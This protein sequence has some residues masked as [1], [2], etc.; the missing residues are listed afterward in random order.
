MNVITPKG[1]NQDFNDVSWKYVILIS[2]C[3]LQGLPPL[4]VQ[5]IHRSIT[6]GYIMKKWSRVEY[7]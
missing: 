3:D 7:S 1:D 5:I 4:V 6:N 2:T